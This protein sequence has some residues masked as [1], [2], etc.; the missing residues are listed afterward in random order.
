[1]TYENE[2]FMVLQYLYGREDMRQ[3]SSTFSSI[4]EAH[5]FVEKSKK[6]GRHTCMGIY[7][8]TEKEEN[9]GFVLVEELIPHTIERKGK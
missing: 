1:M 6:I 5:R 3:G 8:K 2:S 9:N 7:Q 4:E